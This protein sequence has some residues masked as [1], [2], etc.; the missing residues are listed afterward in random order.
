[1]K[2]KNK[3]ILKKNSANLWNEKTLDTFCGIWPKLNFND[4]L[5][6]CKA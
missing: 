2:K 1:M 6:A 4:R 3:N 5:L